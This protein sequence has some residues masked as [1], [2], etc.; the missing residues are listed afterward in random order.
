MIAHI[1]LRITAVTA[2][3]T[4]SSIHT[5]MLYHLDRD[6]VYERQQDSVQQEF[7][8]CGDQIGFAFNFSS[9][10]KYDCELY[11]E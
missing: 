6:T 1:I 11:V 8:D 7:C 5:F 9:C 10:F 4:T 3:F 2:D